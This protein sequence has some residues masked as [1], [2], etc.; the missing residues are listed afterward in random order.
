MV[1]ELTRDNVASSEYVRFR[2]T[3]P[4]LSFS[5]RDFAEFFSHVAALAELVFHFD[6]NSRL[7]LQTFE[8]RTYFTLLRQSDF[9]VQEDSSVLGDEQ[10]FFIDGI[11]V[12]GGYDFSLERHLTRFRP[13]ADAEV[14]SISYNSPIAILIRA[15]SKISA[16]TVAKVM[17][18]YKYVVHH[19]AM[20]R[21]LHAE[22]SLVDEAVVKARLENIKTA[23][24]LHESIKD[25]G[26]RDRFAGVVHDTLLP[27]TDYQVPRLKS[28][29][30]T[31]DEK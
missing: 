30:L 5:P 18:A 25:A 8:A 9:E 29:E 28:I 26:M 22:A 1:Q 31:N 12:D 4:Q 11:V 16:L 21:K 14:V 20:D 3:E 23:M 17:S 7:P 24:K 13:L 15:S 10:G 27:F 19:A 2:F 6:L